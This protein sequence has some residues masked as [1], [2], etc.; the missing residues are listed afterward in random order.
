MDFIKLE[1]EHI[2][3]MY[4][5]RFSVTENPV[6]AHQIQFLQRDQVL[7]DISYGGGWICKINEQYVGYGLG[8]RIPHPLIGGLFVRPEYQK[9]GIGS[10]ILSNITDWFF[11]SGDEQIELTTDVCS[12]AV[13]FYKKRGWFTDGLDEFGQQIMRKRSNGK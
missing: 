9:M 3:E 12:S 6:H 5:I 2:N 10:E 1:C 4:G 13:L 11:S 7:E 8:I